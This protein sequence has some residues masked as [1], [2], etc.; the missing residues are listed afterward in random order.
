MVPSPCGSPG[1]P[2]PM[3]RER[4]DPRAIGRAIDTAAP[5]LE[6]QVGTAGAKKATSAA[7]LPTHRGDRKSTPS[8]LQSLRHLVCRLLLEKKNK[9]LLTSSSGIK[10]RNLI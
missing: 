4:G 6:L 8:E 2:P 5:A 1:L 3:S 7:V 10:L 9:Q